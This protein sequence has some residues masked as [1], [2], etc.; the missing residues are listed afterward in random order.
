MSSRTVV[1]GLA[2]LCFLLLVGQLVFK[3]IV[4]FWI[5]AVLVLAGMIFTTTSELYLLYVFFALWGFFIAY[6]GDRAG[7]VDIYRA[8]VAFFESFTKVKY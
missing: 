3:I 4:P 1:W 5:V 8:I 6:T 2:V 7:L